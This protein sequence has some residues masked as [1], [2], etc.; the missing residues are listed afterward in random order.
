MQK[1]QKVKDSELVRTGIKRVEE[2]VAKRMVRRWEG[3]RR[4]CV[5]IKRLKAREPSITEA[6][7]AA[8]IVP[9]GR[10]DAGLGLF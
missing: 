1:D 6:M 2:A 4:R 3:E 7:N 8:K 5:E 10:V 9:N